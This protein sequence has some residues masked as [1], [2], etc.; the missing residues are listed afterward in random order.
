MR[1]DTESPT[2]PMTNTERWAARIV[3]ASRA[4][5]M[6]SYEEEALTVLNG[7]PIAVDLETSLCREA[8]AL[9]HR[10]CDDEHAV[11]EANEKLASVLEEFG[12]A[13][14]CGAQQ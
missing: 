6:V 5:H 3:A 1:N 12:L 14:R 9:N 7:E 11:Y 8:A 4:G 10:M 2:R 13:D